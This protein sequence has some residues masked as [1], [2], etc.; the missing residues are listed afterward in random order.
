MT[1]QFEKY[2]IVTESSNAWY[3]GVPGTRKNAYRITWSPGLIVLYDNLECIS[4]LDADEFSTLPK[5]ISWI[6]QCSL[7]DFQNKI[8]FYQE[9]QI[10]ELFALMK[11]W[12]TSTHY[13]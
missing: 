12:I 1:T 11:F 2:K 8:N 7:Q 13:K 10:D 5:A 3:I 6:N 9:N 4:L